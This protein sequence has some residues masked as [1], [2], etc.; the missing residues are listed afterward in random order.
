MPSRGVVRQFTE[1]TY[2]HIFNRGVEKRLIFTDNQDYQ[3]FLFYLMVYLM[4]LDKLLIL[5]PELPLRLQRVN[6]SKDIKIACYCLILN[7]FHLL[8]LQL[9]PHAISLLMQRITTAYTHYF[10]NKYHRVGSLVQGPF[11]AIMIENEEQLIHVSRYIH[12]N[13]VVAGLS[14]KAEDYPWSSYNEYIKNDKNSLC[15]KT[16]I[17]NCF[18]TPQDYK[19]FTEDQ[20]GYAKQL[21]DIKHIALDD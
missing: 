14:Q 2:Y 15:F 17:I 13:P 3:V 19:T 1:N 16:D 20:I 18:P 10:N 4:P 5:Y 9:K 7:H 8:L 11:K 6:M 12:L 21:D